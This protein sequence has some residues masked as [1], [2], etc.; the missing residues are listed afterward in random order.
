MTPSVAFA[1]EAV[2]HFDRNAQ[3]ALAIRSKSPRY[4]RPRWLV[5]AVLREQG[6]SLPQIGRDTGGYDH[7][8]VMYG[9][10]RAREEYPSDVFASISRAFDRRVF[11]QTERPFPESLAEAVRHSDNL[12]LPEDPEHAL[13]AM[14]KALNRKGA[15]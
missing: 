5:W 13:K 7:T 3:H 12:R 15:A 6:F 10:N 14:N 4:A 1:I 2:S 8:A 11:D 9:I